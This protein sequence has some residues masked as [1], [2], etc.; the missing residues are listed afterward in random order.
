MANEKQ[1][2]S[3]GRIVHY[4]LPE[5]P[6]IGEHKAAIIVHVPGGPGA[7]LSLFVFPDAGNDGPNWKTPVWVTD[8]VYD[9]T[10]GTAHSWH[11][12]EYVPPVKVGE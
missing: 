7:N 4:V 2:P 10:G 6:S 5:G 8:V 9:E 1:T 11:W 3:V 12:P